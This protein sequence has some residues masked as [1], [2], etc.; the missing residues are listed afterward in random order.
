MYAARVGAE[1]IWWVRSASG[2]RLEEA[3][4]STQCRLA[5]ALSRQ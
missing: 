4:T 3:A 5:K 2:E 1:L